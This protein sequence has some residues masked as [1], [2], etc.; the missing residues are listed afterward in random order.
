[1]HY[2]VRDL[3]ATLLGR[4]DTPVSD[5]TATPETTPPDETVAAPFASV[6]EGTTPIEEASAA[7]AAPGPADALLTAVTDA[8]AKFKAEIIDPALAQIKDAVEAQIPAVKSKLAEIDAKVEAFLA[9]EPV[10]AGVA[11]AVE[12]EA[13]S[14]LH[15]AESGF[16]HLLGLDPQPSAPEEGSAPNTQPTV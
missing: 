10:V 15:E 13:E 2:H 9:K 6:P 8:L 4:K 11:R 5:S 3:F 1:M 7:A 16:E 12:P 14:L